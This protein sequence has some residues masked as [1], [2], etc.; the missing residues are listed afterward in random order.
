[1][2]RPYLSDMIN[3][4]KTMI[5]K[6]HSRDEVIDYETEFGEWKIELTIQISIISSKDSG[7]KS[8]TIIAR[9]VVQKL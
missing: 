4:R 2:I 8:R 1:M 7:E 6:V 3:N 9:V 5:L